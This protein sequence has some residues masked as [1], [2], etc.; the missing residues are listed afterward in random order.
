ME[1]FMKNAIAYALDTG[2]QFAKFGGEFT[3]LKSNLADTAYDVRRWMRKSGRYCLR[4]TG[5]VIKRQPLKSV[6]IALGVGIGI[7]AL[8]GW[9]GTRR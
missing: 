5:T 8:T 1:A 7:G 9:L 2:R 4:E 6:G 3:Q